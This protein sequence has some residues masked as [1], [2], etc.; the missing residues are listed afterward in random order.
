MSSTLASFGVQVAGVAA[1]ALATS[2]TAALM[3]L[4]RSPEYPVS[5]EFHP[6]AALPIH[7]LLPPICWQVLLS[8]LAMAG[9]SAWMLVSSS[10][11]AW[12]MGLGICGWLGLLNVTS[13]F[14]PTV[15]GSGAAART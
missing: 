2:A 14:R 1:S 5:W 4:P 13:R 6:A 10:L 8:A 7:T 15:A 3:L 9:W 11:S 12:C